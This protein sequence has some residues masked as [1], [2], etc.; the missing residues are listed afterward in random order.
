MF[1]NMNCGV[2]CSYNN[3][4]WWFDVLLGARDW[5]DHW[6]QCVWFIPGK[7]IRVSKDEEVHLHA[8]HT[9]ISISYNLKTQ[10]PRTQ[11]EQHD[12]L[13]KDSRLILSPERV[14]IYGDSEWR[15]SMLTA[16]KNTVSPLSFSLTHTHTHEHTYAQ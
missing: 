1:L 9:D 3:A 2:S 14:A 4:I 5:C 6:K 8:I 15:L 16:I 11:I 13:A 10:L 7:G 12:L